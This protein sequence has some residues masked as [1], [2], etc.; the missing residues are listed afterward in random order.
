MEA[1][2]VTNFD[3]VVLRGFEATV[4]PGGSGVYTSNAHDFG[5]VQIWNGLSWTGQNPTGTS[6]QFATRS[7]ADNVTWS[8]WADVNG[9]GNIASPS[10]RYLQYRAQLVSTDL[11][12]SP[13]VEEVVI[14]SSIQPT[15]YSLTVNKDGS[16]TVTSDPAGIDC[17]ATCSYDFNKNTFVTLTAVPAIDFIF[18]GWSG[19]GCSGAGACVVTMTAAK[20]VTATFTPANHPPVAVDDTYTTDKNVALNISAPGV[21]GNDTD[22]DNDQLTA[23]QVTDHHTAR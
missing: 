9:S 12:L 11:N 10:N 8:D 5:G 18:T 2:R 1:V 20:S 13:V 14:N 23:V 22:A 16:G 15:L 7:S 4:V 6:V 19:A 17:G 3:N 21:L